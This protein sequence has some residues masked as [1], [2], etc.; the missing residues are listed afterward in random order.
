[1][2]DFK[3]DRKPIEGFSGYEIDTDGNI[4]SF[5]KVGGRKRGE[6]IISIEHKLKFS[7]D[8]YGY[9]VVNLRKCGKT[10]TKK[11]HRLIAKA[12]IPNPE[13]KPQVNH[14]NG[15]RIDF[16]IGNLYWGNQRENMEDTKRHGTLIQHG[17]KGELNGASKLNN[18]NVLEIKK[19][20]SLG[21]NIKKIA[22]MFKV[23]SCTIYRIK[24]KKNWK[25]L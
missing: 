8:V 1:M 11:V 7:K 21:E 2:Q 17:E 18:L 25:H 24:N 9:L 19:L 20:L 13:N 5:R 4:F 14:K 23:H 10:F 15:N 22:D 16:R 6:R 3:Y 12:F